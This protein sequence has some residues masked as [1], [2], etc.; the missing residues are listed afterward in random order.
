M[1]ILKDGFLRSFPQRVL[2][3][4]P[5][6]L[7]AFPGLQAWRQALD[8]GVKITGCTVHV[9]DHGIDSGPILGQV[10]V[11]VLDGD[12]AERLH[13]RIQEAEHRLYP[14]VIAALARG[15]LRIEGRRS[16]GFIGLESF[17]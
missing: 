10:A 9:V 7:P 14:A 3:I 13:A 8:H 4:H 1:R 2:N 6:L 15:D 16:T 5:S 12:T 17:S 11:P